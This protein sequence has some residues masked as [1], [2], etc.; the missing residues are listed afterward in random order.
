MRGLAG[1]RVL[2][3]G[4]ATGIGRATAL[5]LAEEGAHVAV[6]FVGEARD[7]EAVLTAVR[8][9]SGNGRHLAV[10]ADVAAEGELAAMLAAVVDDL[11]GLDVLVS[12][13]GLERP[14]L[15]HLYPVDDLD[16]VLAVSLRGA[17][18]CARAA[19]R[20]FLDAGQPG[21]IV[22]TSSIHEATPHVD[23]VGYTMT[24]AGLGGMTR[25]LAVAYAANGIRVNAVGPGAIATPMNPAWCDDPD[26]REKAGRTVPLGRVGWPE[27][28]AA[29]IAF[30]ASDEAACITGQTV[31]VD[32]GLMLR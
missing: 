24:N 5:R 14:S 29:A 30:L 18:L 11:G 32:G 13:A 9:R 23:D 4:A 26:E 19:I 25:T 16:R 27:E 28:V 22:S 6:S 31:L 7:A 12:N 2:V 15:P 8:E 3:T 20:H 21:V 10:R 1:K 17:F